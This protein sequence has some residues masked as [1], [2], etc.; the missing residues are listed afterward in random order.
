MR[1]VAV[2]AIAVYLVI[3][4]RAAWVS[5]DSFITMRT[6]D[7][8]LQGRLRWNTDERVQAYTHPLW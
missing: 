4:L 6:V 1:T 3:V 2:A 8:W 7:N 5:D